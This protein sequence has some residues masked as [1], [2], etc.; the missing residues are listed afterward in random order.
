MVSQ[1]QVVDIL[2]ALADPNRLHLF[3]L[4][5]RSDHTNS[6]LMDQTGLRQNL[7]SHH[8]N[9][10]CASG[11]IQ[12]SQSIGDA[13][14]HYYSVDL[15]ATRAFSNWWQQH[16]PSEARPL[17]ALKQPRRVLF[18]CLHNASRS[19]IAE[20]V[21][22]HL[23]PGALIPYSAGIEDVTEPLPPVTLQVLDEH[24]VSLDGLTAKTY[25]ELPN[26][27]F[28]YLISVCDI[29][30][31]NSIPD[32]LSYAEYIHWSLRDPVEGIESEGDQLKMAQ[33][34]YD[35]IVLRLAYFVQ[36]LASQETS[37]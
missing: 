5:L 17:P 9:I 37:A 29:V 28:D 11:L 1:S 18:L 32:T 7:L 8:L 10:L 26:I 2:K 14:R 21:A 19:M 24:Q 34:L 15:R 31:E 3:E 30:H 35:E 23:A 13:R 20:A 33:D 12:A 36:R 27:Q 4:L 6:E 22:R 25:H 16:T